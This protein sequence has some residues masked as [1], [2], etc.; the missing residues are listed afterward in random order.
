MK[1]NDY[2]SVFI[3]MCGRSQSNKRPFIC[4]KMKG[5]QFLEN[6]A[7]YFVFLDVGDE[8]HEEKH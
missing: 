7:N 4:R 6:S 5:W 2:F 3:F 8:L 1:C